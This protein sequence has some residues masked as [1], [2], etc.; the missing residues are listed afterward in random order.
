MLITLSDRT[1]AARIQGWLIREGHANRKLDDGRLIL[2]DDPFVPH[3]VRMALQRDAAVASIEL[4]RSEPRLVARQGD[5]DAAWPFPG[6]IPDVVA[7][8]CSIESRA[9]ADEVAHFLSTLSIGWMRGGTHKVRTSPYEFQGAGLKAAEWLRESCDRY[10]LRAISEV[11]DTPDLEAVASL[12]DIIQ[13]GARQMHNPQFLQK[14]AR[15][16]KPVLLKRGLSATPA[17][18]L[19]AGEYLLEAG[20]PFVAFC[21]RGIRTPSPLK[22]FTLDLQAIPFIKEMTPFPIFIDPSHAAGSSPYVKPLALGAMAAG[23]HGLLVECHPDPA[24]ARSDATQALDFAAM[25]DLVR[26]VRR[27]NLQEVTV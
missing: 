20:A 6:P 4:T 15:L 8:P 17:E 13:I 21:E 3:R 10:N 16:G 19:W 9:V 1:E 22:R 26:Q 24:C 2:V 14:V 11:I 18:W 23:A 25:T 12:L 27:L 5:A 7:G